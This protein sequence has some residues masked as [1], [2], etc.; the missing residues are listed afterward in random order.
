MMRYFRDFFRRCDDVVDSSMRICQV[1]KITILTFVWNNIHLY[2]HL[3]LY[4]VRISSF[5]SLPPNTHMSLATSD[6]R[7]IFDHLVCKFNIWVRKK[8]CKTTYHKKINIVKI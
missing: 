5:L 3:T 1:C 4:L 7:F 2:S 8:G 6:P